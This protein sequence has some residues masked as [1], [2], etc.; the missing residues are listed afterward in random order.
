MKKYTL[1][2]SFI[3]CFSTSLLGKQTV[4]EREV[5]L[6]HH[7]TSLFKSYDDRATVSVRISLKQIK[8]KLPG[9][10]F[11]LQKQ[12]IDQE[13]L[14]NVAGINLYVFSSVEDV[15][16]EFKKHV[17]ETFS[18]YGVTEPKIELIKLTKIQNNFEKDFIGEFK[19]LVSKASNVQ[20]IIYAVF[21]VA[22]SLVAFL[23]IFKKQV[24]LVNGTLSTRFNELVSALQEQGIGTSMES[25]TRDEGSY[26]GSRQESNSTVLEQSMWEAMNVDF[27][28]ALLSD[29][30]WCEKDH[31]ASFVW[32]KMPVAIKKEFMDK[33][34]VDVEYIKY[35]STLDGRDEGFG[36]DPYYLA[37]LSIDKYSNDTISTLVQKQKGFFSF[38]PPMRAQALSLSLEDKL[39]CL[40]QAEKSPLKRE[41]LDSKVENL[42]ASP[43]REL[44]VM[45]EF[46]FDT[47]EEEVELTSQD[48]Q[49]NVVKAFPSLGWSLKLENDQFDKIFNGIQARDLASGLYGASEIVEKILAKIP[50]K[51]AELVRSYMKRSKATQNQVFKLIINK[52]L[53]CLDSDTS[54]E[55]V[56]E[57]KGA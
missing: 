54:E 34:I 26:S 16:E 8:V 4:L 37:S 29:C 22:L 32:S 44:P 13:S 21:T 27:Y 33:N 47:E 9:T 15:P 50:E 57:R 5:S 6:S 20:Y 28:I 55:A 52:T 1:L 3:L 56:I 17:Q 14:G 36:N 38:L 19:S 41:L 11:L 18:N 42:K 40:E 25:L 53:E 31:Y 49:F 23:V 24:G 30:Y 48:V 35:V 43:N 2:L 45:Q 51:K 7:F 12:I 46:E 39:E 10:N